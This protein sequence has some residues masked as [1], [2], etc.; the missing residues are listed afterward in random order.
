MSAPNRSWTSPRT[1]SRDPSCVREAIGELMG[2]FCEALTENASTDFDDLAGS[3][4]LDDEVRASIA[5][6]RFDVDE[7]SFLMT[8]HDGF[9]LKTGEATA[10]SSRTPSGIL[11]HMQ[12]TV[13]DSVQRLGAAVYD[14]GLPHS[15]SGFVNQPAIEIGDNLRD[16]SFRELAKELRSPVRFL[17][18]AQAEEAYELFLNCIGEAVAVAVLRIGHDQAL[19]EAKD[20]VPTIQA[21]WPRFLETCE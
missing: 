3:I 8:P 7:D 9:M 10:N 17:S 21:L 11:V 19:R 1:Y 14:S 18:R 20:I 12:I 2:P 5:A 15:I 16:G 6:T 4:S 13:D